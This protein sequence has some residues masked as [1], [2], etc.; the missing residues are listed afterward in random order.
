M[1]SRVLV[2]R[3]ASQRLNLTQ[4]TEHPAWGAY[5]RHGANVTF[6]RRQPKL[7]PPPTA[8]QH[9]EELLAEVGYDEAAIANLLQGTVCRNKRSWDNRYVEG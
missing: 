6:G 3:S 4:P 7:K 5:D 8:G 2:A 9:A 1:P